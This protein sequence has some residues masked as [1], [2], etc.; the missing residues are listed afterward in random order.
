M[1]RID[2]TDLHV[3]TPAEFRP[4]VPT[5]TAVITAFRRAGAVEEAMRSALAQ[6]HGLHELVV[7]DDASG[8][9]T[10]EVVRRVAA[11]DPRVKIVALPK[12]LGLCGASNAG[13]DAATGE[14]VAFLDSDDVWLP[15]KIATQVAHWSAQA[16]RDT[17]LLAS[18]VLDVTD[19]VIVGQSPTRL[20]AEGEDIG[21]YL[22]LDAGL[23]QTST[24]FMPTAAARRIRFDD[25][26]RRHSDIGLCLR[27]QA[28]G[29][30]IA[31]LEAALAEWRSVSGTVRLS[32][33]GDVTNSLHW[34]RR[35]RPLMRRRSAAAFLANFICTRCLDSRPFLS[36]RAFLGAALVGVGDPVRDVKIAIK[37]LLKGLRLIPTVYS[38]RAE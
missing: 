6:S 19:R 31:V 22:M 25:E 4:G 17:L 27:W 26:T 33:E 30:R 18:R 10:L 9:D 12:N 13:I 36:A 20:P 35:F 24:L 34:Y 37:C 3:S 15:E 32:R 23:I 28:A 14:I 11:S 29:G 2:L 16:D 7:V 21:D 5:V 1:S 8:D 38:T